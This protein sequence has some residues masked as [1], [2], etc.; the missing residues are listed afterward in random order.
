[1]SLS[2]HMKEQARNLRSRMPGGRKA[3]GPEVGGLMDGW[4]DEVWVAAERLADSGFASE[5]T[6]AGGGV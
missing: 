4:T 2:F 6:F 1:M 5:P 3:A